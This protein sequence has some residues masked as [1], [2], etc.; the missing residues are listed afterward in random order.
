MSAPVLT[1]IPAQAECAD[2][3][4]WT[5]TFSDY[6]STGYG[7]TL[8]LAL[9][10]TAATNAAGTGSGT[11]WAFSLAASTTTNLTP[12]VYD[13]AFYATSTATN[14]RTTAGT[15][16]ITFIPNLAATTAKSTA[17]LQLIALNA[18]IL[19]ICGSPNV[20]TNFNGQ[21][22]TKRDLTQLMAMRRELEA[23]VF[24]EKRAAANLRGVVNDGSITPY[25]PLGTNTGA[26]TWP[27]RQG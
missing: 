14:A 26:G 22:V 6:P 20:S 3:V 16:Q 1:S 5:Q 10:G 2:T 8:Y 4:T 9:N 21:A 19:T 11:D 27:W 17:E 7:I 23:Q 15:G 13:Y 12:G 25:F 18:V 24:R